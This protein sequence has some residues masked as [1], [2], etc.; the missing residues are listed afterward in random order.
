MRPQV[1][2]RRQGEVCSATL[3]S[4]EMRTPSSTAVALSRESVSPAPLTVAGG[5]CSTSLARKRSSA[6]ASSSTAAN[7]AGGL[8]HGA[9]LPLAQRMPVLNVQIIAPF[10]TSASLPG[11]PRCLGLLGPARLDRPLMHILRCTNRRTIAPGA[12]CVRVAHNAKQIGQGAQKSGIFQLQIQGPLS[13][14]LGHVPDRCTCRTLASGL[15]RWL[16]HGCNSL[17]W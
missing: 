5:I 7:M 11:L 12:G 10:T 6:A 13:S 1:R 9:S 17:V 15:G 16:F 14:P 3:S 4:P 8:G 2:G